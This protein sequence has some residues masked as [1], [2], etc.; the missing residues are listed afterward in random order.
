MAASTPKSGPGK[1]KVA[2]TVD[3]QLFRELGELLVGRDSTAL[4][5][6]IKNAYDADAT[7]VV[8]HG[9]GLTGA[10]GS[11]TISD[12]GIGMTRKQFVDGFLRI[13]GRGKGLGDRR[14]PQ[15]GRRYTG[16]KGIGRL[17]AHKLAQQ[18]ELRSVA[19]ELPRMEGPRRVRAHIDWGVVEK[20]GTLDRLGP[21]ALEV[22]VAK[23][24]RPTE[25]GTTL[26]LTDLR[27][28]WDEN[29]LRE[30]VREIDSFEPPA[31]LAGPLGDLIGEPLLFERPEIRDGGEDDRFQISLEGDFEVGEDF[32][33]D[34]GKAMTWVVEIVGTPEQITYS[35]APVNDPDPDPEDSFEASVEVADPE[36]QPSFQARV[37]VREGSTRRS[38]SF[39]SQVAGVRVYVEG[40][41]VA[42]YGAPGNDWLELDAY[43]SRRSGG[44]RLDLPGLRSPLEAHRREEL[45][46]L[47]NNSYLGAVFLTQAGAPELKQ[48]INREGFVSSPQ[49]FALRD[50]VRMGLDLLTR[51]RAGR[52]LA[53]RSTRRTPVLLSTE[54]RVQDGI[55]E[56]VEQARSVRAL[57]SGASAGPIL[58][59]AEELISELQKLSRL[60]DEMSEERSVLRSV[61]AVGTQM[62]SFVHEIE[63]IVATAAT[64][65]GLLSHLENAFPGS[66]KDLAEVQETMREVRGRIERQASYLTDV[67]GVRAQRR[68]SRMRLAERVEAAVRLLA[69]AAE[70]LN[71][72]IDNRVDQDLRTPPMLSAEITTA[73]T[74]LLSNAVRAAGENGAIVIGAGA[75]RENPEQVGWLRIENTGA[76]VNPEKGEYWFRPFQS[77]S[78][79]GVDPLLGQG[80]GLGLPLTRSAL[81][82]YGATIAFVKPR[83]ARM[84]TALEA[85][86]S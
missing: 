42:G 77:T 7:K 27:R 60:A 52:R 34:V 44:L 35:F 51:F 22:R 50:S 46:T 40:F 48:L 31:L 21:D 28:V 10:D 72:E 81:A 65:E 64:L 74:N 30:F 5:E 29:E 75:S 15:L 25:A 8:V 26:K 4:T 20:A 58:A 55:E 80:M 11:I 86:F 70:R 71:I 17:A 47:P 13:A 53:K 49:Y 76:E 67:T 41:R 18:L 54:Q 43:Y 56:A 24:K 33:L 23:L 62:A 14:S 16:E 57:A 36:I 82:E 39:V 79:K 12:N 63:N 2:F 61:A 3:T 32:W 84:K 37:F 69:P 6:L 66:A 1:E 9:E 68:R 38:R 73:I 83:R 85:R 19:A 59:E 45:S 78:I